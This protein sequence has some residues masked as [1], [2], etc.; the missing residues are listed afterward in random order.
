VIDQQA[1]GFTQVATVFVP[2]ADQERALDF[3]VGALGFE[4]RVDFVYGGG[5]RWVEVAPPESTFALALVPPGEG[6][7][8]A[9]NVTRCAFVTGDIDATHEALRAAGADVDP[10]VG[11]AGTSRTGL[12]SMAVTIADPQPAQFCFCDPDGN[13]F[14]AVQP[15]KK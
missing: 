13:R 8:A 3:Y 7:E 12:R 1:C 14:L 5:L 2:V 4:K 10:V 6:N 11:R 9:G 15:P